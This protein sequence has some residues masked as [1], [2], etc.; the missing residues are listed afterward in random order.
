MGIWNMF[1]LTGKPLNYGGIRNM[2]GGES[3]FYILMAMVIG[4]NTKHLMITGLMP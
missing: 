3:R 1:L 4:I 2:T